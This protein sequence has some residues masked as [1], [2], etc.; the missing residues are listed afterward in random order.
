MEPMKH[1]GNIP[2]VDTRI[3]V[4][5][6]KEMKKRLL[7]ASKRTGV[8]EP[9]LVRQAVLAVLKEIEKTGS[10]TLPIQLDPKY[11]EAHDPTR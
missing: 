4:R 5:V 9:T 2:Q 7:A 3:S 11:T 10:L 1:N 8:D 6:P